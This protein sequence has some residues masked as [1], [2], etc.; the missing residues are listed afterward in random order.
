ML[1]ASLLCCMGV[2]KAAV[3]DL[4]QMSTDGDIKWYTIKNT[5]SGKYANYVGDATEMT[6]VATPSIS[7]LFYFTAATTVDTEEGFTPVMIH[8]AATAKMLAHFASW[9]DE[10]KAWFLSADARGNLENGP[11]GLHITNSA[12]VG[13][14]NGPAGWNALNDGGSIVPYC[15]IDAGSVFVL[16]EVVDLV[17]VVNV[18]GVKDEAKAELENLSAISSLFPDATKAISDVDAVAPKSNDFNGLK[19]AIEAVEAIVANYKSAV[20]GK[21]VKLTNCAGDSRGGRL[22]GYD[23]GNSR[24][25]AVLLDTDAT[26]WT[27]ESC[28]DG[29]F[30][31]Y[32]FVN[33]LYLGAPGNAA[34]HNKKDEAPSFSLISTASNKGAL[35]CKNGQMVHISNAADANFKVMNY[36]SLTDAASLWMIDVCTIQVGRD[37]YNTYIEAKS[38][39]QTGLLRYAKQLQDKYGLVKSGDKIAVVVNH[40]SG[41]DS[42][43]SSNLLDGNNGTYVHSAYSGEDNT[44]NHYIE[45]ELSEA[46]QN[47]FCYFSKRNNNNRPAVVEVHAGNSADELTKVATFHMAESTDNNVQSYFSEGI[48]LGAAYTHLR[49]VVTATNTG[50]KFFTL[51]E[52]YVL[53]I[54]T[55]TEGIAA[56][57]GASICDTDLDAR[58]AAA[59]IS[60]KNLQLPET[61]AEVKAAL[62]ANVDKHAANP[63]LGQY[64]TAAYNKLK[65]A[66]EACTSIDQLDAVFAAFEEFKKAKNL[67]VFTISNGNVKD[68]AKGKSIYDDN[69]GKLNFKATNVYD[70]TMWWA[71]DMTETAVKVTEKVDI[72]NIGTGNGFWDAASIKITETNEN[73]GAGIADDNIFLFYTVGGSN[74]NTPIHFQSD[75]SEIVHWGS[76]EATSGSAAMFT[77]I[78]NTNDL[79]KLTDEHFSAF[80]ALQDLYDGKKFYNDVVVGN[81]IGEYTGDKAPV[82]AALKSLQDLLS[83]SLKDL[84]NMSLEDLDLANATKKIDDAAKSMTKNLP[85]AGKYYRFRSALA[86]FPVIKA[87]YGDFDENG[88]PIV[89]WK[90]FDEG[91]MEFYW[92]AVET[93]I[94]GIALQNV[95]NSKYLV[96]NETKSGTWS[97]ADAS[98][99]AE[100]DVTILG[101]NETTGKYEYGVIVTGWQMHVLN[102]QSGAGTDGGIVSYPG[103]ANSPSAWYIDEVELPSFFD[104]TYHFTYKD[105]VK[106][107]VTKQVG[108]GAE[109]LAPSTYWE[110]LPYGIK[111]VGEKPAG[112]AAGKAEFNIELGIDLPFE[113]ADSYDNIATWY[114][115]KMQP[116]YP[117]YIEYLADAAYV[118]FADAQVNRDSRDTYSWA[119][120]GDVFGG[121]KLVNKAA[122]AEKA[123][124]STGEG[125]PTM[126]AYVDGTLFKLAFSGVTPKNGE[127]Y[128]CLQCPGDSVIYLNAN[129]SQKK[130]AHWDAADAGST[131]EFIAAGVA[132]DLAVLV[133]ELE[134]KEI[135]YADSVGYY[136]EASAV[137]FNN[138]LDKAKEVKNATDEDIESLLAAAEGLKIRY[139][140]AGKYYQIVSAYQ[141]F[142]DTMAVYNAGTAPGW[143]A[144]DKSDVSFIWTIAPNAEN[145]AYVFKNMA[146]GRCLNGVTMAEKDAA[147]TQLKWLAIG[148]FNVVSDGKILHADGH[149]NGKGKNGK[150]TGNQ[151]SG[152]NAN[153]ASSWKIVEIDAQ[154]EKALQAKAVE[155]KKNALALIAAA[156]EADYYTYADDVIAEAKAAVQS[157]NVETSFTAAM[158]GW[159][160]IEL[161]MAE[162]AA[163]EKSAAPVAGDYIRLK[164]KQYGQYLKAGE[165]DLVL[166]ADANKTTTWLVEEG[167]HKDTIRLKSV[168]TDK[169]I[170]EIRQSTA[171]RMVESND[172]KMFALT[173]Q[174]DVYAVFK[175][176][177]GGTHAYGHINDGGKLVGWTPDADATQWVIQKVTPMEITYIYNEDFLDEAKVVVGKGNTYK[178][179]SPY[180]FAKVVGCNVDGE[181]LTANENGEFSFEV[182]DLEAAVVVTLE[183]NLPFVTTTIENGKFAD[184]TEWH[185]VKQHSNQN[186]IWQVNEDLTTVTTVA[187]TLLNM[188][189][190]RQLWCFVGN[191]VEG[192]KIYNK[193]VGAGKSL[194]DTDDAASFAADAVS[195]SLDKTSVSTSWTNPFCLKSAKLNKYLNHQGN[196]L[197]YYGNNDAGS[198]MT[199]M[200]ITSMVEK[201]VAGW[202]VWLSLDKNVVGSLLSTEGL[203]A[204]I[205]AYQAAPSK[206]NE[207]AVNAYIDDAPKSEISAGK[208]YQI[209]SA[210][211]SFK[212]VKGLYANDSVPAWKTF[213]A[214]DKSFYWTITPKADTTF[215]FQNLQDEHYL[216]G[217]TLVEEDTVKTKLQW[218]APGEFNIVS[219][220]KVLHANGHGG[221]AGDAGDI[222]GHSAG[223]N[224]ASSWTIVEVEAA[225][226][227]DITYDYQYKGVTK[228]TKTTSIKLGGAYPDFE[229]V[230]PWGIKIADSK[231]EGEVSE[232]KTVV[233]NLVDD[234]LPFKYV[235]DYAAVEEWYYLKFH[236]N[237]KNYLYYDATLDYLDA[238][239]TAIDRKAKEAYSWAFVGNPFDGFS[240]VN[241]LAGDKMV[242]SSAVEPQG[243]KEYPKMVTADTITMGNKVWDLTKS[244]YGT[245]GF[246]MAYDGTT[247]RLNKQDG[248][249]CYWIGAA[250]FGSTFMVEVCSPAAELAALVAEAKK[251]NLENAGEIGCYTQAYAD[252][253]T[254]AIEKAEAV[255]EATDADVL[256]LETALNAVEY[257]FPEVGKFYR[258]KNAKSN[259]YMSGNKEDITLLA[260]GAEAVST[261]FYLGEGNTLLSYNAGRY[262][263]C[264]AKNYSALGTA[265]EGEFNIAYGGMKAGVITY[266]NN[267]Y[268]TFGDRAD[269]AGLDRGSLAPNQDGYNW[270]VEEVTWLPVA[271]NTDYG[272]ATLTSPVALSTYKYGSTAERRVNAYTGTLD[273]DA[274][275]LTRVDNE[276]GIIPANTPV[277]I[278]YLADAENGY[279]FLQIVDSDKEAVESDLVGTIAAEAKDSK[280]AYTLQGNAD[281]N[282][283][284]FKKY[285]GENLVA[286][287]AYLDVETAAAAI[288][289]RKGEDD[290]TT[291]IENAD[292]ESVVVIYDLTGRRVEKMEKG[293]YIVNGRK[294]YV[295]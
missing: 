217:V 147:E 163:V 42:Q 208:Y 19:E 99:G 167:N 253:L 47:I 195:W 84:A 241:K 294:V 204:L 199:A 222:I 7:S 295:K 103:E 263:D 86:G 120:V 43:P 157:V 56:L 262:L 165:S 142:A 287:K 10:G 113:V 184:D 117:A 232:S 141:E 268:W 228:A 233:V 64:T 139:P 219:N 38:T 250:D 2:V 23:K 132:S 177:T 76:Y 214:D 57:A 34:V 119:L 104:I 140:E 68:Y 181:T 40:P 203:P 52:F 207:D 78:G 277:V 264:Q 100:I 255:T 70:K 190:D 151:D 189:S 9:T 71:L 210:L 115:A 51:S 148:K 179:T 251:V 17:S 153:N 8:N 169:Y 135:S 66:Y 236:A 5:R 22:L 209:V 33:D 216:N 98:T 201:H 166:S 138:A 69:D 162:L 109:Y 270:I 48:D 193:A 85:V 182:K 267:S 175:E 131:I 197:K 145:T 237:D 225:F 243:N 173:N 35:V 247:K 282:G 58:L 129:A 221:G 220:G 185:V 125:N 245:D 224:S 186:W 92:K 128:F 130:L 174:A 152:N 96:G 4:P 49:F 260:N 188:Y 46:T 21:S 12:A 198:T 124:A 143:K 290:G 91:S 94:G 215:T 88:E 136:T 158:D 13:E 238:T 248:K 101:K 171:V 252:A 111:I 230:A 54:N 274:L 26:V 105:V 87:V 289:I 202:N 59:E 45:V 281:K 226:F 187:D 275:V 161:V 24:A 257:M 102:H 27:F 269:G 97:M 60:L 183:D 192:I 6:Q 276:D 288:S 205:Q 50:T 279:V 256:A 246:F 283:V 211:Q 194:A 41:G 261:I 79:N 118:E 291:G 25:A 154:G 239:K 280:N 272:Y 235:A 31:L 137:A 108:A 95:K 106:H 72:Y 44:T 285:T 242:L 271:I 259:N 172:A 14:W 53:P 231:P 67:P 292:T 258:L 32:N 218:L 212:E 244:S 168:S 266:K 36:Y 110:K 29:T 62:D 284:V 83:V 126:G 55:V 123:L 15:A 90:T 191:A 170:G 121:F 240:V 77:Y 134:K 107:S 150:I 133:A 223:A 127:E 293:I 265:H 206:V 234:A 249:V 116:N 278:E 82:V 227:Y 20:N 63:D 144:L 160:A 74:D 18:K 213:N 73:D 176:T 89:R 1:L 149:N 65:A 81:A 286:F 3:T 61:L 254:E 93:S 30:K 159:A 273:D 155:A 196:S 180:P 112:K 114:Y 75:Y 16:E 11:A 200:S 146:D 229:Y 80:A 164:N 37:E 156:E 122:G 39:I 28:E 178:V